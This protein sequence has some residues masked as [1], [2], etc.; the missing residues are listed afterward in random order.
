MP[1]D[2]RRRLLKDALL[3]LASGAFLAVHFACWVWVRLSSRIGTSDHCRPYCCNCL[4]AVCCLDSAIV[5]I[6]ACGMTV[7]IYGMLLQTIHHT[8]LT[9][10]MLYGST[11]PLLIAMTTLVLRKP[12]SKGKRTLLSSCI[13]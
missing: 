10:A 12:I 13:R 4:S 9:H 11:A 6:H 3:I 7:N 2:E 5:I 1:A 8:S